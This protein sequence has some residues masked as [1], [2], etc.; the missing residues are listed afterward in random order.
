M[1]IEETFR[2]LYEETYKY[3][4]GE[5]YLYDFSAAIFTTW[6]EGSSLEKELACRLMMRWKDYLENDMWERYRDTK[7]SDNRPEWSDF[8]KNWLSHQKQMHATHPG[9]V[10]ALE[11]LEAEP[12]DTF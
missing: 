1:N 10:A 11:K 8:R 5:S 9:F 3:M 2:K 7:H 4:D 12:R 6:S